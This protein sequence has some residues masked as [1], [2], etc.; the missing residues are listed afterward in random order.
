MT[1]QLPDGIDRMAVN[2]ALTTLTERWDLS[3]ACLVVQT[4]IGLPKIPSK[5]T[6]TLSLSSNQRPTIRGLT[7]EHGMVATEGPERVRTAQKLGPP[8][9]AI[10][11]IG[12]FKVMNVHD[13]GNAVAAIAF[14][15]F[16]NDPLLLLGQQSPQPVF[17]LE[18]PP[19]VP[20]P[21]GLFR[22]DSV[23]QKAP[24]WMSLRM[25]F[26]RLCAPR[27]RTITRSY[28][29]VKTTLHII[30]DEEFDSIVPAP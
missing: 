15:P 10:A 8:P 16:Q 1:W 7:P 19:P 30:T 29:S 26:Y 12:S 14:G 24:L 4:F 5:K 20:V 22:I 11:Y 28:G 2:A 25:L 27:V 23:P 21:I 3:A 6:W 13:E 9:S 17:T 18:Y